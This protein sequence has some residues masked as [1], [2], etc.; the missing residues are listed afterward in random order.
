M[1]SGGRHG[2]CLAER[3]TD[4]NYPEYH[5]GQI[6]S[7]K[8][9]TQQEAENG[10]RKHAELPLHQRR[11]SPH[12]KSRGKPANQCDD[13]TRKTHEP[14][15]LAKWA[16][17][18]STKRKIDECENRTND[19]PDKLHVSGADHVIRVVQIHVECPT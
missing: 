8:D 2:V 5:P 12:Q 13:D 9:A 7:K 1:P 16:H 4:P 11:I 18:P 15:W 10:S 17:R 14:D 6:P 19:R 3:K